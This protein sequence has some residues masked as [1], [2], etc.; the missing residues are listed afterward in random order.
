MTLQHIRIEKLFCASSFW[1]NVLQ[2]LPFLQEAPSPGFGYPLDGLCFSILGS[3]FQPPTLVGFALQSFCLSL[4]GRNSVSTTSLRSCAFLHNLIGHVSALQRV[5]PTQ[6]AESLVASRRINPRRDRMLSWAQWSSRFSP[7]V[8]GPKII[9][10]FE[11]PSHPYP[12]STS[13][14]RDS[15]ISRAYV[16]RRLAFPLRGA[17]LLGLS[18]RLSPPS[19]RKGNLPRVIFSP[20]R[21]EGSY[22]PSASPLCG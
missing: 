17:D 20:R 15:R 12:L 18:G 14:W 7:F 10:L 11:L 16:P 5:Y 8:D 13:Q 2:G 1:E 3:L 19:L 21:A 6:K 9:S 4:G 22:N